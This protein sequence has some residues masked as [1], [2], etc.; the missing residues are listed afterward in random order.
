MWYERREEWLDFRYPGEGAVVYHPY[1]GGLH[2]LP[3][4]AAALLDF[5]NQGPQAFPT[6]LDQLERR[7]S[8]E[9]A[10]SAEELRIMLGE[11][12]EAGVLRRCPTSERES[13]S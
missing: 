10:A 13:T 9:E 4:T 1:E 3:E 7:F 5:L 12:C 6:L 2:A 11:L 8:R